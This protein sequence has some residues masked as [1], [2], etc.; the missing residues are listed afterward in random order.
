VDVLDI[1]QPDV[2]DMILNEIVPGVRRSA[3]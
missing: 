1:N 3:S 2:L